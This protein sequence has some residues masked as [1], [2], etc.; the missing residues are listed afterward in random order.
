MRLRPV[1]EAWV[2]F[3]WL[4]LFSTG[5]VLLGLSL[6]SVPLWRVEGE[7]WREILFRLRGPRTLLAWVTGGGLALAGAVLQA[8]FRNPLVSPLTLGVAGAAAFGGVLGLLLPWVPPPVSAVLWVLLTLWGVYRIGHVEGGLHLPVALLAGVVLNFFFSA[9]ILLLQYWAD[10]ARLFAVVRWLMGGLQV[11]GW[12]Q[13]LMVTAVVVPLALVLLS[14][15]PYLDLLSQGEE[16][17]HGLGLN[18][19][20]TLRVLYVA[21]SLLVGVPLSFTGPI[22]FVGLMVPHFLRMVLGPSHR[23]LLPAAFLG[24]GGL[25]VLADAL[26][27]WAFSP[28]E[29]PAGVITALLGT[30][31]FLVLLLRS[32]SRLPFGGG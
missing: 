27:R 19:Q 7:L 31:Y 29:L 1:S 16:V 6:G 5:A 14:F 17:A 4:A 10:S 26:G 25:L 11:V 18:L 24:G 12:E 9:L 3:L 2:K 30:P 23:F 22:G 13:P 32:R 28:S 20:A 8:L 15:G 21:V